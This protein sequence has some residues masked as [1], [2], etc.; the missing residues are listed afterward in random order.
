M[1][2]ATLLQMATEG[3]FASDDSARYGADGPWQS[4]ATVLD[5]LRLDNV[6]EPATSLDDV[7]P[8]PNSEI[9]GDLTTEPSGLPDRS[10]TR[11]IRR[12]S[13]PGWKTYWAPDSQDEAPAPEKPQSV[14]A[15]ELPTDAI[16]SFAMTVESSV[17][18]EPTSSTTEFVESKFSERD[19]HAAGSD[20]RFGDLN[21]WKQERTDRLDRLLKIVAE[22]EASTAREAQA[23]N[24]PVA[25]T[26]LDPNGSEQNQILETTA[27]GSTSQ[28]AVLQNPPRS[29][30]LREEKWEETLARWR[31]SVPD[32]RFV[33]PLLLLSSLVW[34]FW[35]M[36]QRSIAKTYRSMYSDLCRLRD[37][38]LNKTG[39]EEFVSHSQTTLDELL[40]KLSQR[41]A[42]QDPDT[43][44][45]LS[46][47][48]D[49]LQPLL[50]NP[51]QRNTIH[52]DMLKKLLAQWDHTHHI[53]AA[54]EPATEQPPRS[55]SATPVGSGNSSESTKPVAVESNSPTP[56]AESKPSE[57][58]AAN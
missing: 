54:P 15:T 51:R 11:P 32:W 42:S 16:R 9:I 29:T 21:A 45:L 49:C 44:L 43:Q 12:S 37:Q 25:E 20:G 6:P 46:I 7:T 56:K 40:P 8:E 4:V 27:E 26:C 14:L 23:A 10:E 48:R 53:A 38:P 18:H 30:V 58:D 36:S 47:G 2:A 1:S 39:M 52:E 34:Y 19:P 31:R 22:R 28:S 3:A 17:A 35:P 24:V 33:L 50:K 13:I 41:A 5:A 57:K 55:S